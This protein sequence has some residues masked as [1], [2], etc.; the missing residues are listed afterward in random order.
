M[1]F[2]FSDGQEMLRMTARDFLAKECPKSAVRQLC[3]D[4]SGYDPQMWGKMAEL[5]WQGLVLPEEYGGSAADFMDMAILMEEM[6]RNILPA[7]FSP[8]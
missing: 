1:D 4:E 6:G 7:P 8:P 3:L 2:G 5:G